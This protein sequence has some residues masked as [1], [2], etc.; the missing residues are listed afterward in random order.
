MANAVIDVI[1]RINVRFNISV[2]L[3]SDRN[4]IKPEDFVYKE[5]ILDNHHRSNINMSIC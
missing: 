5:M 2:R 3:V 4:I 1:Y